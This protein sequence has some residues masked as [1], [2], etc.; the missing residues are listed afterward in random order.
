VLCLGFEGQDCSTVHLVVE[1]DG[2]GAILA[3]ANTTLATLVA[4]N[5]NVDAGCTNIYPGE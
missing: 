1:G 5:P 3:A 4:N 2:C